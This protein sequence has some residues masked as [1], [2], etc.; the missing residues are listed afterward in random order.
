MAMTARDKAIARQAG[1]KVDMPKG[2]ADRRAAAATMK[3]SGVQSLSG[4]S[5]AQGQVARFK[6]EQNELRKQYNDPNTSD[7]RKAEIVQDLRGVSRDLNNAN[8]AAAINY[9]IRTQGPQAVLPGGGL[10]GTDAG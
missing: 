7:E 3:Q 5:G 4:L 2:I 8:R 1:V 10:A 6:T 9:V